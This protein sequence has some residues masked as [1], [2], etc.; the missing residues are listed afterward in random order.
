[1][2]FD[3]GY[4]ISGILDRHTARRLDNRN[5]GP[6]DLGNYCVTVHVRCRQNFL[7]GNALP[8]QISSYL[9]GEQ[10]GW[11]SDENIGHGISFMV[12]HSVVGYI[13]LCPDHF[14][15]RRREPDTILALTIK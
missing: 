8:A 5:H 13:L 15:A 14:T 2:R 7:K 3:I 12:R 9:A 1:M 4:D 6:A 10:A 11:R